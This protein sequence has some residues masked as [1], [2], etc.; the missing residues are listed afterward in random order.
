MVYTREGSGYL[1]V[2][3]YTLLTETTVISPASVEYTDE[4]SLSA[5]FSASSLLSA[6]MPFLSIFDA[7]SL[8]TV[9]RFTLLF[10]LA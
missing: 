4:S 8:Y 10:G 1:G 2:C 9:S 5:T 6:D 7:K 3:G